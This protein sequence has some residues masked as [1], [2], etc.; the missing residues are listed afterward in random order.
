VEETLC[1]VK[2]PAIQKYQKITEIIKTNKKD[3]NQAIMSFRP[4]L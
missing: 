1:F 3:K 4:C 2:E